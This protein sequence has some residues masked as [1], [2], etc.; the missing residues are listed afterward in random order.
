MKPAAPFS[1]GIFAQAL[2]ILFSG[3]AGQLS[4]LAVISI[5]DLPSST[6]G[7]PVTSV[8][9]YDDKNHLYD[10]VI[11]LPPSTPASGKLVFHNLANDEEYS[12]DEGG[13][14]SSDLGLRL[15]IAGN[16]PE[17]WDAQV[18]LYF[19]DEGGKSH[20]LWRSYC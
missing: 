8:G 10:V 1:I 20:L 12:P 17:G 7:G 9:A 15:H 16:L 11:D 5:T 6:L 3:P 14:Y 2:E 4:D 19:V 13:D 18:E